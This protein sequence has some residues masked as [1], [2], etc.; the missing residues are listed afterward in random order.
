MAA[1]E[2]RLPLNLAIT[3]HVILAL[4]AIYLPDILNSKPKIEDVYTVNLV[5]M[6]DVPA[7]KEQPE[8]SQ[9]APAK[10]A[11]PKQEPPKPAPKP[12]QPKPEPAIAI[13]EKAVEPAEVAAPAEPKLISLNPSKRKIK[14]E[15]APPPK[16]RTND[17]DKSRRQKLAEMIRAEQKA[18]EEARILAEEA[19]IEKKLMEASLERLRQTVTR[20]PASPSPAPAQQSTGQASALE[21]RYYAAIA[22]KVQPYWSLPEYKTWDPSLVATVVIT[23]DSTGEMIDIFFEKKSGDKDF[24]RFVSKA[25]DDTGQLPPIPPALKKQR[26]EIGLHFTREGIR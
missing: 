4:G 3:F 16:P 15:I 21:K 1:K 10:P 26:M 18:M 6:A 5:N 14:K 13:P 25:L 11:K 8:Q 2:W 23:I 12:V 17:A 7:A 24:D 19:E 20:A 9:P 22:A